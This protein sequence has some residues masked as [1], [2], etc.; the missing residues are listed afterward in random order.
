MLYVGHFSLDGFEDK[1]RHGYLTSLVDAGSVDEALDRFRKL[2]EGFQGER[3]VFNDVASIYLDV[4][5]QVKKVPPKGILA[6]MVTRPGELSPAITSML[7]DLDEN[8]C[9]AYSVAPEG[10]EGQE[11][12]I[13]PF[14]TRP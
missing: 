2:L 5:I 11:V 1:P 3:D 12:A 10:E 7:P 6:H 4:V 14:V 9:E 8:Y 13:N